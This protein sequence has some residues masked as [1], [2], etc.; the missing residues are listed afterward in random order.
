VT[1]K[2]ASFDFRQLRRAGRS[3]DAEAASGSLHVT[4][5]SVR[6][7]V[8][9]RVLWGLPENIA[10]DI[11]LVGPW[12]SLSGSCNGPLRTSTCM[13]TRQ[14]SVQITW[15]PTSA[16]LADIRSRRTMP[17][18]CGGARPASSA[19]RAEPASVPVSFGPPGYSPTTDLAWFGSAVQRHWR[20]NKPVRHRQRRPRAHGRSQDISEISRFATSAGL[21]GWIP[22]LAGLV[23]ECVTEASAVSDFQMVSASGPI[24]STRAS[25]KYGL[26]LRQIHLVRPCEVRVLRRQYADGDPSRGRRRRLLQHQLDVIP[27]LVP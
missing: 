6:S 22:V 2:I 9:P 25:R 11:R 27:E 15:R 24:A 8:V 16:A 7:D 5:R 17:L 13:V 21:T 26:G 12:R 3:Q 20:A 1:L 23:S 14:P 4:W 10:A 19:V 18:A